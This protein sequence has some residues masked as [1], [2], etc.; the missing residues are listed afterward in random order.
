MSDRL[1]D[2][3]DELIPKN[4]ILEP[5]FPTGPSPEPVKNPKIPL[6]NHLRNRKIIT[7]HHK[8]EYLTMLWPS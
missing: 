1:T 6:T 2:F 7:F 8:K 4:L 3:R 5:D